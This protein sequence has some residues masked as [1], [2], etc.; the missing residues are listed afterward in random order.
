MR[1]LVLHV[2]HGADY[3][4]ALDLLYLSFLIPCLL[5]RGVC[6]ASCLAL[7]LFATMFAWWSIANLPLLLLY[8]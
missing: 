6:A 8:A 7:M 2:V 1:A 4:A 3:K 5:L